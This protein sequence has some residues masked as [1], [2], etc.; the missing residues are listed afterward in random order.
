MLD[1]EYSKELAFM[2]KIIRET[3][4]SY[5]PQD[6]SSDILTE[7]KQSF[8]LVTS[9]DKNIETTLIQKIKDEFPDDSI[10]SE[11]FNS[12]E[13]ISG[14]TWTID[15]IDGTCNMAKQ[16]PQFGIQMSFVVDGEI[17]C[18]TIYTITGELFYALKGCGAFLNDTR[19]FSQPHELEMSV[20]SFGDFP[21]SSKDNSDKTLAAV[22]KLK[23]RIMKIR[24]FGAACLDYC[25]LASGR[26]D[27][28]F[29]YTK[30]PWDIFP[31]ILLCSEAGCKV[32]GMNGEEYSL[33]STGVIATNNE[34][35]LKIVLSE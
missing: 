34:Q 6:Y 9:V 3:F 2:K 20:A 23:D 11:E 8:D 21:H 14:R 7:K 29:M 17:T 30:N 18:S 12:T 4:L 33:N 5:V 25:Y 35:L 13:I 32:C 31:G 19:L 24:F 16:I 1:N 10:L 15:P 27:I 26:T 28:V 22:A